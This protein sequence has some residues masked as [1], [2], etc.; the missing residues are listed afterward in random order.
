VNARRVAVR[1]IAWLGAWVGSKES[2]ELLSQRLIDALCIR[3]TTDLDNNVTLWCAASRQDLDNLDAAPRTGL[4]A[5]DV[6]DF[7]LPSVVS[8]SHLAGTSALEVGADDSLDAFDDE[9]D[10]RCNA[11]NMTCALILLE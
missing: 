11:A 4:S 3:K 2:I 6:T 1:S 5:M 8:E 9:A 10:P 7:E